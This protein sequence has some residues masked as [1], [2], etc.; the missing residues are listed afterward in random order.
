MSLPLSLFYCFA[1]LAAL[2]AGAILFI[3]NVFY[4]ALLLLVGLLSLAGI[5]VLT[6]A[7]FVAVTQILVYAGGILVVIIFGIMLTSKIAHKPLYVENTRWL[8]GILVGLLFLGMIS[9]LIY[10]TTLP[11]TA[12]FEFQ[13]HIIHRVGLEM[14]TIYV[15]PFEIVGI[16]LLIALIAAAV[17][18]SGKPN[19]RPTPP[20]RSTIQ[21][22]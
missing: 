9:Y 7:E 11:T 6:F 12:P 15:L 20:E 2:S 22:L 13:Q 19:P 3:R 14:M 5:Y 8:G 18:A 16:L 1:L 4:G 10:T 17:M 21:D